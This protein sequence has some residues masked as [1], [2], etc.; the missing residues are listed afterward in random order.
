MTRS[1]ILLEQ[2]LSSWNSGFAVV[3][4]VAYGHVHVCDFKR[5]PPNFSKVPA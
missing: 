1:T 5:A 3:I 2:W 4:D